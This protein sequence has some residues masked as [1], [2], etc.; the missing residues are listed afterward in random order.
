[1]VRTK[2][3]CTSPALSSRPPPH[4][5]VSQVAALNPDG[6]LFFSSV[7]GGSGVWSWSSVTV[8]G[9]GFITTVPK[10]ATWAGGGSRHLGVHVGCAQALRAYMG[11]KAQTAR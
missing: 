11:R 3:M 4:L 9:A 7:T 8:V 5:T 10:G 1:M 6:S 2:K